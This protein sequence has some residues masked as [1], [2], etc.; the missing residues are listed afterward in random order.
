VL[1]DAA[2]RALATGAPLRFA[3]AGQGPLEGEIRALHA[4]LALGERFRLLGYRQD[5]PRLL[6]G[7]DLFVLA[8][9][10]EGLPVS[11]MEALALG[12]PVVAPAVGGLPELVTDGVNG[13]LVAPGDASALALAL[14]AATDPGRRAE[15]AA[16]AATT[17]PHD[18]RTATAAIEDVY[19][20]VLAARRR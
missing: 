20:S 4:R 12:V 11:V 16:N 13:L 19:R 2:A 1:L 9:R 15:L 7:A 8:S 18:A 14:I 17:P 10:H 5:A 6:A 3:A